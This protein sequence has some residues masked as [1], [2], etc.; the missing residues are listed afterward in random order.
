VATTKV[1]DVDGGAPRGAGGKVRQR[2]SLKLKT[3]MVGLREVSE[4]EIW[5]CSAFGACPSGKAVNGCRNLGQ[6]LKE[7]LE[8]ILPLLRLDTSADAFLGAWTC[9]VPFLEGYVTVH[10]SRCIY[11]VVRSNRG[12]ATH[13]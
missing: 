1:E 9:R 7:L 6:M 12:A 2:P 5:D 8:H 11:Q 4:L 3:S 10:V 13:R